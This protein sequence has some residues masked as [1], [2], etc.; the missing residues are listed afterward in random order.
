MHWV[1]CFGSTKFKCC[2]G[3]FRKSDTY[4]TQC[5]EPLVI[6]CKWLTLRWTVTKTL[7][8]YTYTRLLCKM[9]S[10]VCPGGGVVTYP[11]RHCSAACQRFPPSWSSDNY[12]CITCLY[13]I[14]Y[15]LYNI[16]KIN[17][18]ILPSFCGDI[19]YLN[20][21]TGAGQHLWTTLVVKRPNVH[22]TTSRNAKVSVGQQEM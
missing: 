2:R 16:R 21:E 5:E 20:R 4:W 3:M 8:S 10:V 14:I 12:I 13:Y 6:D 11:T 9:C 18:S 15:M 17:T 19:T 22:S 1:V 7:I